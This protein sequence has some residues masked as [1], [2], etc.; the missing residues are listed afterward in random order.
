MLPHK[1]NDFNNKNNA[2]QWLI[3]AV[4]CFLLCVVFICGISFAR[5]VD[6]WNGRFDA[7]VAQWKIKV[8]GIS[9]ADTAAASKIAVTMLPD[10]VDSTVAAGKIKPGQT[11]YFN[12]EI[13]PD[14][15]ETSFSYTVEADVVMSK[16][17]AGMS[18][19]G[20]SINGGSRIEFAVGADRVVEDTVTLPD[21][22][23]FTPGDKITVRFYWTWRDV[24]YDEFDEYSIV[25]TA[26]VTQYVGDAGSSVNAEGG[27]TL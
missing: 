7:D 9:L 16:L 2:K 20:Y 18:I 4:A 27:Q 26:V 6:G 3:I 23:I 17:P 10:T 12:V 1:R 13:D 21:A 19:D 24:A 22:G 25:V 11:G 5:Y 8:N 15:T 14:G